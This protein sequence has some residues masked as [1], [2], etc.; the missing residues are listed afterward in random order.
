LQI[1]LA[2]LKGIKKKKRRSTPS[3]PSY[4]DGLTPTAVSS[5]PSK[6]QAVSK[7]SGLEGAESAL[8]GE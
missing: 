7:R 2:A 3:S 4:S 5:R 8:M 6:F 1:G